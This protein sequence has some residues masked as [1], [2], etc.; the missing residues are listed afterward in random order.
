LEITQQADYA[1]RAVLELALHTDEVCIASS[2]IARQQSIP[3]PFLAKIVARL[4][5]VGIVTTQRG[6]SGGI[7][8]ARPASEITLLDVIEAIDGPVTLNRCMRHPSDCPRSGACAVHPVW[9]AI[10]ADLRLRLNRFHFALLA[11][12]ARNKS[13]ISSIPMTYLFT[14]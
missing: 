7:R 2:E 10:C 11:E 8:L 5:A 6:V 4:A 14:G 9:L 12:D 3:A 13:G 1:V